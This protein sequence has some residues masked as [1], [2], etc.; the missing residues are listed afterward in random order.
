MLCWIR[1]LSGSDR[2]RIE[3]SSA[4]T[5]LWSHQAMLPFFIDLYHLIL[6]QESETGKSHALNFCPSS[7]AKPP[8]WNFQN[9][10]Q[11]D[12]FKHSETWNNFSPVLWV[13]QVHC[14]SKWTKDSL[15]SD[16]ASLQDINKTEDLFLLHI[17]YPSSPPN[18]LSVK[19]WSVK[20]YFQ[21]LI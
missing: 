17:W 9:M 3:I 19:F 21:F 15:S 5:L 6:W 4:I 14:L 20:S 18:Q 13:I 8:S 11:A 12:S 1:V 16:T 2:N 10:S 7:E